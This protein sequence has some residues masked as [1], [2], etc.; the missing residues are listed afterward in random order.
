MNPEAIIAGA[1]AALSVVAGLYSAQA[2]RRSVMLQ[3]QLDAETKL[4]D[5]AAL[6]ER[7]LHQ[8]RQPLL[9]AA[10][11]LQGRLFNIVAQD[12]LGSY[13]R[14]RAEHDDDR[15]YARDYTVYV[16]AEYLCWVE[17]LRRDAR[18]DDLL[19]DDTH[20]GLMKCL[21]SIQF[22]LQD[23][24]QASTA[25][26]VFRGRQR[27]LAEL[28]M[29]PTGSTE[30]PRTECMGYATFCRRLDD[31]HFAGWFAPL[32]SD[33]DTVAAESAEDSA[34]L[35]RLQNELITLM[36]L[37]DPE[38]VRVPLEFRRRLNES[39]PVPVQR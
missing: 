4:Q 25:F 20:R 23:D 16:I 7:V 29:V 22:A 6:A 37:L 39:T 2:N 1:S 8:Y 17:I 21:A 15:R 28:M 12:Y 33:V 38:R 34:R 3:Q 24:G 36:D 27:A 14:D 32:R 19:T 35:A 5:A 30:G 31:A 18:F 26:R 11:A 10:H 13:Y 9:D